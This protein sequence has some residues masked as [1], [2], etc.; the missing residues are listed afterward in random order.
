MRLRKNRIVEREAVNAVRSF[1]EAAGC[2]FQEVEASNDYGK[3]AYV[4]ISAEGTITGTCVALQIKG[5]EKYV[6]ANGYAIPVDDHYEIWRTSSV[7]IA[8][9]VYDTLEKQL[10]WGNITKYLLHKAKDEVSTIPIRREQ[11]LTLT[12]LQFEFR[13]DFEILSGHVLDDPIL[14]LC[15]EPQDGQISALYDCFALGRGDARIFIA[16]RYLM[17]LLSGDALRIAIRILSHLTPHPD[18]FWTENNWVPQYI[19]EGVRQHFSW[20]RDDIIL[21]LSQIGFDE[22]DRGRLGE[23]LYMLFLEDR[24]IKAKMQEV[25]LFALSTQKRDVALSA[26][27]LTVA[28]AGENGIKKYEELLH[29]NPEFRALD[30]VPEIGTELREYGYISVF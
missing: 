23:D 14:K 19:K 20:S 9:I 1:F 12:T 8:G 3:D 18:I 27:I 11:V 25:A 22:W 6:R 15:A 16:L 26:F 28:W 2:V 4:D 7:P 29:A 24:E 17:L 5:G 30:L 10:Y 13:Q 21:L